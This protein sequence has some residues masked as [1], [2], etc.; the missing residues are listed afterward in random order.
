MYRTRCVLRFQLTRPRA[1]K[2]IVLR[3]SS[4]ASFRAYLS[5]TFLL[6]P[7]IAVTNCLIAKNN[8]LMKALYEPC[9]TVLI[10]TKLSDASFFPFSVCQVCEKRETFFISGEFRSALRSCVIYSCSVTIV[11]IRTR[12]TFIFLRV[13]SLA[14]S[15]ADLSDTFLFLPF[16]DL[17]NYLIA[18]NNLPMKALYEPCV[19]VPIHINHLTRLFSVCVIQSCS[20]TMVAISTR[21]TFIDQQVLRVF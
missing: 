7:L 15:R 20:V 13:S 3:V 12:E 11:A 16:F 2:I 21:E 1:Q 8:L 14:S 6:L 4:L 19:T 17:T 9:V 5:D 18:K 10:H